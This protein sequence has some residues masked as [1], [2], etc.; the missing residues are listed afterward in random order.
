[1]STVSS[2]E[3]VENE[4]R[5]EDAEFERKA[6]NFEKNAINFAKFLCCCGWGLQLYFVFSGVWST[7]YLFGTAVLTVG[8]GTFVLYKSRN[9]LWAILAPLSSQA[10][11][12]FIGFF[13][14]AGMIICLKNGPP[15]F[16]DDNTEK[17]PFSGSE[18][19]PRER[20][21]LGLLGTSIKFA[22][23]CVFCLFLVQRSG[24]SYLQHMKSQQNFIKPQY[25][26]FIRTDNSKLEDLAKQ[27]P[28]L[29]GL[30]KKF[31]FEKRAAP[32]YESGSLSRYS[33]ESESD[34]KITTPDD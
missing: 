13:T 12:F 32:R 11:L 1:M 14:T 25:K 8:F 5:A 15:L 10:G 29:S 34:N 30:P 31:K 27:F 6:K 21:W 19:S 9:P 18:F 24:V 17:S 7:G 3:K 28:E 23:V 2:F 33:A 26:E 20:K 16:E 22:A 4:I